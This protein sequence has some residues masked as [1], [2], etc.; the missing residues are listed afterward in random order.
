VISV[1][2]TTALYIFVILMS[3]SAYPEGC[4]SWLDY[5]TNLDKFEGIEGLP[6]FY[7]AYHYMGDVGVGILMV[8]LMALVLS[9]LI[10]MLRAVSRLCYSV[11]QD[12]VLPERFARLNDKQ[13]PVNAIILAV[14]V[15]MPLPF[16]GRTTIGW[17]VDTTTIGA[18]IIYGFSTV[19]VFKVAGQELAAGNRSVLKN[20]LISGICIP[21]LFTFLAIL[22][23]P[24]VFSDHTIETE[25]YVL[26]IAWSIL[27][28][29]F[30]NVVIQKD[31]ARN[32]GKALIVWIALLAFIILMSLTL[33]ERLNEGQENVIVDEISGYID[34][35]V[36]HGVA[37][38]KDGFL[39]E[40]L[41][42][43][44][45]ADNM[46]V[47]IVAGLFGLSLIVLVTNYRSMRNWEKKAL[48]ERDEAHAVAFRDSLTGVK[49]KH[50]F[51]VE[52]GKME[53]L[54]VD[55]EVDEFGVIV[56]DV[57]GLKQIND[58][59]G[60]KAGDEYIC[61][62]CRMLCEY[63]KHSPVFRVGG[64]EFVVLLRG[65]DYDSRHEI[66]DN[67]NREIEGNIGKGKAVISLGLAEFDPSTDKSFHEVFQRADGRMYQ[68]KMQLKSMGAVTR[69]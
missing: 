9:S 45:D 53:T 63:F 41:R 55:G 68:R 28:V 42:Q 37:E 24:N 43:L 5:I 25:T 69:D 64:D 22:L 49:S 51:A 20:R 6:A 65:Q 15:S 48:E 66:M 2:V 26:M 17:V 60:H 67:I 16:L 62:S 4:S 10:G 31:H 40:K 14:L 33:A 36:A 46:S 13:I 56:C 23:M 47:F 27:G 18:T 11:A 32:F 29:V 3:V 58:T 44:H 21:I 35:S 52:E 12:G 34:D 57:N 50:A 7:A 1:I 38:N 30:F 19:A 39:S 54:I 8:S 61:T 59:L